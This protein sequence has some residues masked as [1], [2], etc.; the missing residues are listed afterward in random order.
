M[1]LKSPTG[2]RRERAKWLDDR[3]LDLFKIREE[4]RELQS[5]RQSNPANNVDTGLTHF[6]EA[7]LDH[8]FEVSNFVRI[9]GGGTNDLFSFDFQNEEAQRKKLLLR[10]KKGA[11]IITDLRREAQMMRVAR[12]WMPVPEPLMVIEDPQ[13]FGAQALVCEF[14][15][16]V[17][18]LDPSERKMSGM[19]VS[20]PEKHRTSIA[21]EFVTYIAQLHSRPID[22]EKLSA[23]AVPKAGGI[24]SVSR[25][26][27]FW[28]A[29]WEEDKL[30]EH[31][32]I[33]LASEWLWEN[34]PPTET[35]SHL[36]GDYRN[37]NFLVDPHTGSIT[38]ILDW[39]M[40]GVGDRH[41]DLAYTMF[42]TFGSY[43][44]AGQFLVSGLLPTREFVELY[45]R[46]SGLQIDFD[47]IRYYAV[48][49][50]YWSTIALIGTGLSNAKQGF[51]DLEV[52]ANIM[53]AKGTVSGQAILKTLA[54]SE[55]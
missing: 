19:G 35:L 39:E 33:S 23:F 50:M 55:G 36:H 43:G 46:E 41:R 52:M 49:N 3:D 31:P 54:A 17:Q 2:S 9:A 29:V 14:V 25:E 30:E 8:T 1:E 40:C 13:Y 51:T 34:R 12:Q 24:E 45:E 27:A 53:A 11:S 42:K 47:R 6:L 5:S 16:G 10:V 20:F 48:F 7:E 22:R 18:S 32:I 28:D 26:L 37:G 44:D 38:A 15:D 4:T 21:R